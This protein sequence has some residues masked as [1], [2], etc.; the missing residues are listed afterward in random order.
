MADRDIRWIQR[1]R[2]FS[3]AL[4]ELG[5]GV[6]LAS[7]RPLSKLEQQGLIQGFE[8]THELAWKTL[9]DFLEERG[10]AVIYGSKDAT[11]EAFKLA[12]I[13]NG[14]IW[15]RMI[16]SR[17]RS[18]HTYDQAIADRIAAD[19]RESY[20][21]EFEKLQSTLKTLERENR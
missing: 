6:A 15:M 7:Q 20:Y 2:N 18:S 3:R 19:I 5:E 21:P 13:E 1:F 10:N 9:K 11:R 14:E 17:N 8:F 4:S 16:E 12:L